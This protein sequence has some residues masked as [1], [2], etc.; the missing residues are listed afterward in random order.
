MCLQNWT[1]YFHEK[2]FFF[3]TK[4][5]KGKLVII[6]IGYYQHNKFIFF[7]A[8]QKVNMLIPIEAHA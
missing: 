5:R 8:V 6:D 4:K 7:V 2:S 1:S 3:L